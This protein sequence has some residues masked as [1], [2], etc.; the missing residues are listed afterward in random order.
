MEAIGCD[1]QIYLA[2]LK[3]H[4]AMLERQERTK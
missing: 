3:D 4:L 1:C 2:L